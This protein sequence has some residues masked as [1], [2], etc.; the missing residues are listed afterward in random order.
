MDFVSEQQS[1]FNIVFDQFQVVFDRLRMNSY[2]IDWYEGVDFI[3]E[4]APFEKD[5]AEVH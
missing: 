3:V 4:P 2:W 5:L 1:R